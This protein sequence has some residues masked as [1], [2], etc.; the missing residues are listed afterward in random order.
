[1][2][3]TG[4]DKGDDFDPCVQAEKVQ[5]F[6]EHWAEKGYIKLTLM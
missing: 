3:L 6:P 5:S 1:M 2:A 4:L